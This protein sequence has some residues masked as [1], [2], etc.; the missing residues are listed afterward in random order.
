MWMPCHCYQT[1]HRRVTVLQASIGWTPIRATVSDVNPGSSVDQVGSLHVVRVS[2]LWVARQSVVH[3]QMDGCVRMALDTLV[4]LPITCTAIQRLGPQRVYHAHL[5]TTAVE[6][7]LL[8]V[9]REPSLLLGWK[10]VFY[11]NPA[12]YRLN[13][14][15]MAVRIVQLAKPPTTH[16][17]VV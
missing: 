2:I 15:L 13:V 17:Q 5:V 7:T 1:Q 12:R 8:R 9:P 14:H 11:A 16:A 10:D 3:V 6:D 4:K